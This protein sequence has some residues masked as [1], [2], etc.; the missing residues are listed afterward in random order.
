MQPFIIG[1]T[2]ASGSGKSYTLDCIRSMMPI[3][4]VCFLSL[5]NYYKPKEFQQKDEQGEF[6][7]DLPSS[8]DIKRVQEDIQQLLAGNE[9]IKE[10]Y[11]FNN[12]EKDTNTILIKP[13]PLL[14]I[15]GLFLFYFDT[16][17]SLCNLKIFLDVP[18]DIAL[19]RRLTRDIKERGYDP[20]QILYQ[21][22]HHVLPS[23][24]QYIQ[25]YKA[26]AQ[27]VLSSDQSL[28]KELNFIFQEWNIPGYEQSST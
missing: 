12:P 2:G 3:D 7:F 15:E 20:Q 17:S 27:Y 24:E 6:N 22:E 9:V 28:K 1:I 8:I 19:E 18:S 16:L 4:Q 25:P 21:W 13:A 26:K 23:F 10:E 14:V 11:H 5:D